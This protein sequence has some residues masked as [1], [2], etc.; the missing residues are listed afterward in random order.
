MPW[1]IKEGVHEGGSLGMTRIPL[2]RAALKKLFLPARFAFTALGVCATITFAPQEEPVRL[3]LAVGSGLGGKG[4]CAA[5][6]ALPIIL[7]LCGI[8]L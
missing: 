3:R 7:Q 2:D 1:R 4:L 8:C 6:A 5:H